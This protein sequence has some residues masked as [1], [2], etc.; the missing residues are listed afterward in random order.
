MMEDY[1]QIV[2]TTEKRKDAEK[3]AGALKT[4]WNGSAM[5]LKRDEC[6]G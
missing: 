1:I 3:I 2:T 6:H 4:I 5:N